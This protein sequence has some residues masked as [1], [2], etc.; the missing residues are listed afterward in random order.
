MLQLVLMNRE[1]DLMRLEPYKLDL[2][3]WVEKIKSSTFNRRHNSTITLFCTT[4]IMFQTIIN[5]S[6]ILFEFLPNKCMCD[7]F[8]CSRMLLIFRY[9]EFCVVIRC[10]KLEHTMW[11]RIVQI[12][13]PVLS[14]TKGCNKM[15]TVKIKIMMFLPS[16]RLHYLVI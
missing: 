9:F 11:C 4:T 3:Y 14:N 13:Q 7:T 2:E 10:R 6:T 8:W 12:M 1:S 16:V 15:V 5:S